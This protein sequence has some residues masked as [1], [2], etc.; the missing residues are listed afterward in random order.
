MERE[1]E[2]LFRCLQISNL[3]KKFILLDIEVRSSNNNN[4]IHTTTAMFHYSG[5]FSLFL[6]RSKFLLYFRG[7][8]TEHG[9][10]NEQEGSHRSWTHFLLFIYLFC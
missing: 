4:A 6:L 2:S 5:S 3:V 7:G 8:S 10:L 9:S 1:R